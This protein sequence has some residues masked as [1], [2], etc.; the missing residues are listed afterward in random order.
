MKNIKSELI[1]LMLVSE[2]GAKYTTSEIL[3]Y[4]GMENTNSNAKLLKQAMN[5]LEEYYVHKKINVTDEDGKRH[6]LRGYV[7]INTVCEVEEES[8]EVNDFWHEQT[9]EE[10]KEFELEQ[11]TYNQMISM[12]ELMKKLL[13]GEIRL[14]Y[15]EL[16]EYYQFAKEEVFNDYSYLNAN[17]F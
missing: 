15:E 3:D 2:V 13:I 11:Y 5:E 10:E 7:V 4:L 14:H 16:L 9:E 17:Q 1:Q 8:T 12:S 6:T